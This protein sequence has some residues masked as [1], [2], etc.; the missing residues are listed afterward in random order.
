MALMTYLILVNAKFSATM[1][2]LSLLGGAGDD[3]DD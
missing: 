1:W 3:L 2:L